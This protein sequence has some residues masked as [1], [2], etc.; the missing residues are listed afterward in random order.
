MPDPS[1]AE[2][3]EQAIAAWNRGEDPI[4]LGLVADEVVYVNPPE[5][6]EPGIRHGPEGWRTAMRGVG[7]SFEVLGIDLERV[8]ETGDRAAALVNFRIR[9]RASGADASREQGMVFTVRDGKI[10][11][12]E[13]W[14]NHRDTLAAVGRSE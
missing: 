13:W 11:R 3:A 1:A 8:V 10:V 5:A 6:I 7:G 4:D 2:V 12:F 14:P 9:G